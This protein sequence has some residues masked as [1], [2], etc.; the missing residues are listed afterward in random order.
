M[1]GWAWCML[2]CV[3]GVDVA[4]TKKGESFRGDQAN[5]QHVSLRLIDLVDLAEANEAGRPH[6]ASTE[7]SVPGTRT[8][9]HGFSGQE[10][11]SA[12]VGHIALSRCSET[13]DAGHPL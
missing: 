1:T 3:A 2:P 5:R 11:V 12:G 13:P 10:E 7:V 4:C 9:D 8:P 6:W